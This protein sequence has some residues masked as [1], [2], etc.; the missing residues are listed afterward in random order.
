M[1]PS[2]RIVK[3]LCAFLCSDTAA[4]PVFEENRS[5]SGILSLQK[6]SSG[7]AAAPQQDI[8]P[9]QKEAQLMKRGAE[10]ALHKLCS[11]FGGR[12]FDIVPNLWTCMSA[13]LIEVFGNDVQ[14]PG[15]LEADQAVPANAVLGQEVIDTLTV[16][17]TVVPYLSKDLW[18]KV[19]VKLEDLL[20]ILIT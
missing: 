15:A 19:F 6:E 16:M 7:K 13:K 8:P 14:S 5:E 4:T 3:N 12:V 1:N 17:T 20:N 2:D 18:Y 11:Q 9:Q 10:I